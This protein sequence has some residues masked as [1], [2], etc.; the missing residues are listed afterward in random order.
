MVRINAYPDGGI[1][2]EPYIG[3][4][5]HFSDRCKALCRWASHTAKAANQDLE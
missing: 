3:V 2:T 4:R 5:P 1:L